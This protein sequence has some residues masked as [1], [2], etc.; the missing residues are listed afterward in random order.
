MLHDPTPCFP[1]MEPL[2]CR[3]ISQLGGGLKV[4]PSA[5]NGITLS[6]TGDK[7]SPDQEFRIQ[8]IQ[9]SDTAVSLIQSCAHGGFLAVAG[10]M[11]KKSLCFVSSDKIKGDDEV[12]L[13]TL[14]L[15]NNEEIMNRGVSQSYLIQTM[16]S[17]MPVLCDD[18]GKI[19]FSENGSLAID[20]KGRSALWKLEVLS[21]ELCFL[22][23]KSRDDGADIFKNISLDWN[24]KLSAIEVF[25]GNEVWRFVDVPGQD[26]H[27]WINSWTHEDKVLCC[28]GDGKVNITKLELPLTRT[29]LWSAAKIEGRGVL[30]KSAESGMYLA[31]RPDKESPL[32]VLD[33]LDG[34]DCFYWSFEPANRSTFRVVTN[35]ALQA[36]TKNAG[37]SNEEAE[38]E[39]NLP[40]ARYLSVAELTNKS[41]NLTTRMVYC[42]PNQSKSTEW[43]LLYTGGGSMTIRHHEKSWS[44]NQGPDTGKVDNGAWYLAVDSNVYAPSTLVLSKKQYIWRAHG[45]LQMVV[46]QPQGE[47]PTCLALERGKA[48]P[49][50]VEMLEVDNPENSAHTWI[51]ALEPCMPDKG[52]TKSQVWG[53]GLGA[54]AAATGAFV[55]PTVVLWGV[56]A[57]G[58]GSSGILAGSS[59]AA[60]MSAEASAAGGMIAAGGTVA[61]L[62][63]IGAAGLGVAGTTSVAIGGGALVGGS[64]AGANSVLSSD[65]SANNNT[66]IVSSDEVKS[67]NRPFAGWK[68]W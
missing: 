61:T 45:S 58:F 7:R 22:Q 62:Q 41:I 10:E 55:A 53:M 2:K 42:T 5:K 60:L 18:Q 13:C 59:A 34:A 6:K 48:Y 17:K 51:W 65:G 37:D 31:L 66:E 4:F 35:E 49:T 56:G 67:A 14:L 16:K 46:F 36:S 50:T 20:I 30:I 29:A 52:T 8:P 54:V 33:D 21:G 3:F 47:D 1:C 38:A 25:G 57:Y 44:S 12:E 63:S 19:F 11:G 43:K 39:D 68:G 32:C 23:N 27:F 15:S 28:N 26:G 24:G 9:L 40:T 64:I